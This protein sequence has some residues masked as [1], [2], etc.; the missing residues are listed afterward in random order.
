MSALATERLEALLR[1]RG[2]LPAVAIAAELG[3]SQPTISRLLCGMGRR[4]V[5]IR[6]A[7]ASRYALSCEVAYAGSHWPLYRIDANGRPETLGQLHALHGDN[8]YFEPDGLRP[9]FLHQD[10]DSGLF[11]GLPW[12]LDDQRPQGFLGR[13]FA[14]RIAGEINMAEDILRWRVDGIVLGLLRHGENQ[15]GDLVLGETA[16]QRALQAILAPADTVSTT[17]RIVRFPQ[18]ADAVLRGEDVG[19]SAAGEQPKFAITLRSDDGYLP[20]IVKF[21][22]NVASPSGRRWADLLICEHHAGIA[23]REHGLPAAQSEIVEADNRI[24]LQSARF[25][26]TPTLG[27]SGFVSL[28]ALDAAF[29]GH[30]RIDWWRFAAQL[31]QDGWLSLGDARLLRLFG[32]Y[33]M[34]ISNSD[35]HLGN[36]ALRLADVRPLAL[37]PAYD[38]LPMRFRPASSGDI[39]ERRYEVT[40]P[41]PEHKA[42][43][44]DAA[45]MAQVFWRRVV[46]D[47]RISVEF[48]A[49][50]ADAHTVLTRALT[51]LSV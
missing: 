22:G 2:P 43:W 49:I 50:A 44:L 5:R 46:D 51:H 47:A 31:Q 7:R 6:R 48:R 3:V 40:M 23:L 26:R 16:L 21:S 33:G 13:S 30:G 19:S 12:F 8:F 10:F 39:V 17:A 1:V 42:D 15:P 9:V 36:A 25:D 24:F 28:A 18:L 11:P 27:R 32:W 45:R 41:I 38:M 37:A 4:I 29:Y 34:L 20:A 35:M 14:R